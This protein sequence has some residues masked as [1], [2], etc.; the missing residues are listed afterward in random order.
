MPSCTVQ[1]H[2]EGS[3][4]CWTEC[5]FQLTHCCPWSMTE[6]CCCYRQGKFAHAAHFTLRCGRQPSSG[7]YQTPLVALACNFE[8]SASGSLSYHSATTL[9]HEFGHALHSLLSRTQY[10]HLSGAC[11]VSCQ[12]WCMQCAD[13]AQTESV[14]SLLC[15]A[16]E[17]TLRGHCWSIISAHMN[18]IQPI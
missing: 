2:I 3:H 9:F 16:V 13:G 14:G 6:L 4:H 10:Q 12:L 7:P 1:T 18:G 15:A 17:L 11:P 5:T 8:Q